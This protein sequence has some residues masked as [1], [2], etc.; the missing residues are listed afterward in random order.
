MSSL[1]AGL[2]IGFGPLLMAVFLDPRPGES[3]G[4]ATRLV[5][6]LLYSI[7]FVVVVI[8]RSE[9]FTEH[10]I[11]AVLPVLSGEAGLR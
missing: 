5:L 1:S 6:A 11:M 8:G 3:R 7:G 4:S 10:T 2:D 9:L